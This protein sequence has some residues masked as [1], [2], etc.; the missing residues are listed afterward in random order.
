[1]ALSPLRD[2]SLFS[3][4]GKP[5]LTSRL[6]GQLRLVL[7]ANP[8]EQVFV[9]PATNTYFSLSLWIGGVGYFFKDGVIRSPRIST[10]L[11]FAEQGQI[12]L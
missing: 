12:D 11:L 6:E 2:P 9:F 8:L 10:R 1:M 7:P 3:R 4:I 5:L